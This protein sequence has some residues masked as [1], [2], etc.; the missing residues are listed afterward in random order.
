M[1]AATTANVNGLA[2]DASATA[3]A[4]PA[5]STSGAA[6][7]PGSPNGS[8]NMNTKRKRDDSEE[9][10]TGGAS[11]ADQ[12]MAYAPSALPPVKASPAPS[13]L[14]DKTKAET[15]ASSD[16]EATPGPVTTSTAGNHDEK[17]L[18][19]DYFDVLFR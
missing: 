10:D 2:A 17:R 12:A 11:D 13:T 14:A 6:A 5:N 18:I 15:T 16:K 9:E 8:Q 19:R 7:T 4:S 1:A 3:G